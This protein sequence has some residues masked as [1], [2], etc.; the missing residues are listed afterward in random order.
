MTQPARNHDETSSAPA[1]ARDRNKANT[2][3]Q[4]VLKKLRRKRG[5]SISELCV[6]TG[7]QPHSIRSLISNLRKTGLAVSRS[8]STSGANR[9]ACVN[10]A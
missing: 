8:K 2:K 7:W 1:A 3:K 4:L 9:Y 5:A 6:I 10:E